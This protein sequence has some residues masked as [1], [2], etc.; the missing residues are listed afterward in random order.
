MG[1]IAASTM[2]PFA[3]FHYTVEKRKEKKTPE[4]KKMKDN[5]FLVRIMIWLSFQLL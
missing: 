1:V 5:N 3:H 4:R 2:Q